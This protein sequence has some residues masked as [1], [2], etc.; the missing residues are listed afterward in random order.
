MPVIKGGAIETLLQYVID[1]EYGQ[2]YRGFTAKAAM[3]PWQRKDTYNL[4]S[5]HANS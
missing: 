5:N 2:K 1:E 4:F 3:I